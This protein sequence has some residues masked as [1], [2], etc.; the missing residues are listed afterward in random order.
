MKPFLLNAFA[1]N[2]V[3]H[4]SPGLWRHPRDRSREF[5]RLPLWLDLARLW[6]RGLFDG[7]F[8]ADVLGPYDV[9]GGNARGAVRSG[10][11]LP[12]HDPMLLVPAMAAVTRNLGF[13]VTASLSYEPP[14]LMAR[15]FS[16]LDHLTEGRI[17]WNVVTSY[18]DSAARALG[19]SRQRAH[20]DRYD[21]AEDYMAAITRLWRDSW[22]AGAVLTDPVRGYADPDR[23]HVIRHKSAFLSMEALH[24]C[25]PSPQGMPVVYQ[26]GSSPR[27]QEFAARHAE[28]VFVSGPSASVVGPR[29]ARLRQS[30]VAAGRAPD[31][32]KVLSLATAILGATPAEAR[33]KLSDYRSYVDPEGALVLMA[34]WLGVDWSEYRLDQK[35]RFIET[36]A[37]RAAMENFTRADPAREWTV[38]DV[39]E[40]VGIGGA[41]PVFVGSGGQVAE[42]MRDWAEQTGVDGFNLAYALLPESF[43]DAINLLVPELQT[44]G[45]YKT[46]Y[47]AGTLR[48]KLFGDPAAREVA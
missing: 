16:T 47:A 42:R 1:M 33:D 45:L 7:V 43:E 19:M 48:Q 21:F 3:T 30:L 26:A 34:G 23:V 27:G 32:V 37:G 39:A 25:E 22:E 5:N 9:Y 4:Q 24:L 44:R 18:L 31:S 35:V 28:C 8:L 13:G 15:R 36:D 38:G 11:Q 20:D 12:A 46:A 14:Y 40:H 41:G 17:G 6:E 29:V 10:A 2:T